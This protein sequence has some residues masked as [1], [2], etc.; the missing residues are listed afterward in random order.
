[1]GTVSRVE[2]GELPERGV[3]GERGVAP[4]ITLLERVQLCSR[5]RALAAHDH[6]CPGRIPGQT[7][8]GQDA[9]DLGQAG[10]VAVAA[11]GVD[12]I[13]PHR[14]RDGSDRDPFPLGDRPA[15]RELAVHRGVTETTDVGEELLRAA[16]AISPDQDRGAVPVHVRKLGEGGVQ[17]GDV[18][19]GGIATRVALPQLSG[20]ELA[21]VVAER[22]QP[23]I[24]EG[25]L[26]L[27]TS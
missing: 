5:V 3:G 22:Q 12:R 21:G 20:E 24:A 6:P 4:P 2:V 19:G 18:V 9:G 1:M 14:L 25:L 10:A 11:V 7:T 17:D 16:G 8:S 15:D 13:G 23:V 26:V 27:C